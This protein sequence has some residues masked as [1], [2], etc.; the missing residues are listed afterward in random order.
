[1]SYCSCKVS[2]SRDCVWNACN[3]LKPKSNRLK[4]LKNDQMLS[5]L[6]SCHD[7]TSYVIL[8]RWPLPNHK[9]TYMWIVYM[10]LD[11]DCN[12]IFT[13]ILFLIFPTSPV[14]NT[15][16]SMLKCSTYRYRHLSNS[17]FVPSIVSY[18]TWKGCKWDD[19]TKKEASVEKMH[20][21][22]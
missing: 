3:V 14:Q 19:V 12:F 15:Y 9:L 7:M 22:L 5:S 10:I 4:K 2:N 6:C 20:V 16:A 21:Y 11:M 1:M 17:R 13:S 18:D 8:I